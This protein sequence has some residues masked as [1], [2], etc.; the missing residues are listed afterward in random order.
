MNGISELY[1][2]THTLNVIMLNRETF[3]PQADITYESFFERAMQ[4]TASSRLTPEIS[5][6]IRR[7]L[8]GCQCSGTTLAVACNHKNIRILFY[9][10]RNKQMKSIEK[11]KN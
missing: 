1:I 4:G 9:I 8:L 3:P 5:L 7:P 2:R 10:E 6:V 11:T